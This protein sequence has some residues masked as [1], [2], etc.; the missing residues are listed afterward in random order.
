MIQFR[1]KSKLTCRYF[2]GFHPFMRIAPVKEEEVYLK[3]RLVVY[4]EVI[5]DRELDVVKRLATP[6]VKSIY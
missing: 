2:Y 4:H 1:L 6:R 5:T 3:P